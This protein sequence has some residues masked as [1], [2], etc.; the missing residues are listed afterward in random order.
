MPST[1]AAPP[2]PRATTLRTLRSE[3]E[4]IQKID[5]NNNMSISVNHLHQYP[6]AAN[7]VGVSAIKTFFPDVDEELLEEFVNKRK[8]MTD[9]NKTGLVLTRKSAQPYFLN[10][11]QTGCFYTYN[12]VYKYLLG[13]APN[14]RDANIRLPRIETMHNLINDLEDS[15][16]T[17]QVTALKNVV[18]STH[19]NNLR[20]W[21]MKLNI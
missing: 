9:T 17:Y 6:P 7:P 11:M 16:C 19:M 3:F 5:E 18:P 20:H 4:V 1:V 10:T 8:P 14:P 2:S 13:I 15:K 21:N 12:E